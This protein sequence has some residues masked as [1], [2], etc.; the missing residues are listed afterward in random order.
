MWGAIL[1]LLNYFIIHEI[2]IHCWGIKQIIFNTDLIQV[3][4]CSLEENDVSRM[5]GFKSTNHLMTLRSNLSLHMKFGRQYSLR[6]KKTNVYY[7][8]NKI[9]PRAS[10]NNQFHFYKRFESIYQRIIR[11]TIKH[12]WH[13]YISNEHINK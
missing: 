3:K 11:S 6:V 9:L 8:A 5:S 4:T 2:H 1:I 10:S 13:L 12:G 7:L